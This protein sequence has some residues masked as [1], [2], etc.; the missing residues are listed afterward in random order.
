MSLSTLQTLR[1]TVAALRQVTEE[2]Q[3]QLAAGIGLTQEKVSRRQSGATVWTLDDVDALAAHWGLAV[4]DLLAG[5]TRATEAYSTRHRPAPAAAAPLPATFAPAPAPAPAATAGPTPTQAPRPAP[6][7][8]GPAPRRSTRTE[9]YS[10]LTPVPDSWVRPGR[11]TDVTTQPAAPGPAAEQDTV[12]ASEHLTP[13]PA[14]PLPLAVA[15][16]LDRGPDGELLLTDPA[17]CARC[18]RPTPYRAGGRPLHAGGWCTPAPAPAASVEPAGLADAAQQAV[19]AALGQPPAPATTTP[20]PAPSEPAEAPAPTPAAEQEPAAAPHPATLAPAAA[21][22]PVRTEPASLAELL[23]LIR[24]PVERELARHG[25]DVD[26]A[27]AAL[28]KKAIP[29]AMALLAVSRVGARY[30][31][32]DHPPLPD[33]L[34]KA[35]K[36]SADQVWEARPKWKNSALIKSAETELTVSALDMNGAY[37]SALKSHLP[38][39]KL[40][41]NTSGVWDPKQAGL[42]LVTPP[43]WEHPDLPN[44]LGSR[45][46]AGPLWLTSSTMRMLQRLAG[47]KFGLCEAPVI[48]EAW[49]AYSTENILENFRQALGSARDTA[50]AEHDAVTLEY[51]KAM[52][53]KFVSTIGLSTA[54]HKMKRPDW[55]HIIRAQ[56]FANLWWKG[57]KAHDAGLT[58]VQMMGTDELHLVGDWRSVFPEGRKVTEVKLKDTYTIGGGK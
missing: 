43:A 19:H 38:I 6:G 2:T 24:R 28:V 55:M 30:E 48:H 44:P 50:I 52:Y 57:K 36:A 21:G 3:G 5:P 7:R 35:S 8:A 10:P 41:H 37:L 47:P 20:A 56:A 13:T 25:G 42:Y 22:A 15:V 51:V 23:D 16:D 9:P 53:S 27:T 46:E 54:N 40:S 18:A 45:D 26:A 49:T 11:R 29:D 32:T 39:G 12:P 17:P 33:I 31:H 34:K 14:E 1:I 4:L 58:L